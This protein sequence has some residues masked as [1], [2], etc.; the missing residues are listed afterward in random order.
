MKTKD[1]SPEGY[2]P[3]GTSDK[4]SRFAGAGAAAA[5]AVGIG[6]AGTAYAR[7]G[8]DED[9]IPD[10]IDEAQEA[11]APQD[12]AAQH[13]SH[14]ASGTA[15]SQSA[16]N[17]HSHAQESEEQGYE[18]PED[19]VADDDMAS[20]DEIDL[21]KDEN[22]D[23][24]VN[25]D[26]IAEAIIAEE[27]VDPAD[28]DMANVVNFDDIGTVY[29][30]DGDSFAAAAVHDN[31]GNSYVMVDVD[32]DQVFDELYDDQGNYVCEMP[33]NV[34]MDDAELGLSDSGTY[35]AQNDTDDTDQFGADTISNDILG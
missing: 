10:D 12:A 25:P 18:P 26:E 32:N 20:V 14:A 2:S 11:D 23:D 24:Y 29:N 16:S 27:Q 7:S 6:V 8:G 34:T 3:K 1:I 13:H 31:M 17:P 4:K 35:L 30:V 33:G 21:S 28:I 22:T 15:S 5:A 9:V 19:N